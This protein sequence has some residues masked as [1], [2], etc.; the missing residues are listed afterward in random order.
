MG[1]SSQTQDL[2]VIGVLLEVHSARVTGI[3]FVPMDIL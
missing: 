3:G 1:G 2:A